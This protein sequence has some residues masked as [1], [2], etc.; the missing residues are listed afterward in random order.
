MKLS[1]R[2][3]FILFV[4][5]VAFALAQAL[6]WIIFMARVVGEKVDIAKELGGSPELV[7]Q[8]H[9]QEITRQIMVGTEG[10]F[11]LV[12]ILLGA[13]LIYRA[14]VR[15]EELKFHQQNF[16]SAVTHELKT[17]LASIKLYLD[18]LESAK[19]APEKKEMI[20]PRMKEDVARLEKLVEDIL[21][22]GRFDR[23]GYHIEKSRFDL[24]A[25]VTERLDVVARVPSKVPKSIDR[26]IPNGVYVHGD[27]SAMGR[28]V[29]AI[30]ENALKYHN[31]E[32]VHISVRLG[33]D[34]DWISLAIADE[35]IGFEPKE[36]S[37]IFE[38]FYRV[39]DEMTRRN[40]G[41]GL[42]LYLCREIIRAHGGSVTARS[43]GAGKG[44]EFTITLKRADG[45]ENDTD[46]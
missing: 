6:W 3:A 18:T 34:G 27:R 33:T 22:A 1:P 17:P 4:S 28:A 26:E 2:A 38:R 10:V 14:L 11:F 31:D 39:G 32:T 42:G 15:T 9:R 8:I 46:S 30:L 44:A 16:L 25:L 23:S 37:A 7:E 43:D 40:S 45:Y 5:M 29:D 41:T 21:E 35:G 24:S 20:V 19:V 13:W 36:A 12:L